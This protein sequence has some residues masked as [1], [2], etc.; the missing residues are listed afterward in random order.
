MSADL[1]GH[2]RLFPIVTSKRPDMVVW[3]KERKVVHLIELTCPHEDNVDAAKVRKDERYEALV[4]EC[5]K[6][7]G[8][9]A[10]HFK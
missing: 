4:R 3:C 10:T 2:G 8:W 6:D 7:A 5:N 1:A 9:R